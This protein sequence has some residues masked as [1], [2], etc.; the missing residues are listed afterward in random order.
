MSP[1]G[2]LN[3]VLTYCLAQLSAT[4]IVMSQAQQTLPSGDPTGN[5]PKKTEKEVHY[6]TVDSSIEIRGA[7]PTSV[8][9]VGGLRGK[10]VP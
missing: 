1:W 2:L 9:E 10:R 6:T 3:V 5:E 7:G 8:Q 4:Q